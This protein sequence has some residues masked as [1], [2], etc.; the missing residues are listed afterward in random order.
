MG[1]GILEFSIL[2]LLVLVN[3]FFALAEM[4]I[5]SAKDVRLQQMAE[6]G[7]TGAADARRLTKE[8]GSFLS[9]VQIGITLVGVATGAFGGS[10]LAVQIAPL[11]SWIPG[12]GRFAEVISVALMVLL[13]TYLSLVLGELVPKRLAIT[14]PE[15]YA[16]Q[17]A[18]F[19]MRLSRWGRPIVSFLNGS[20]NAVI[21]LL[22]IKSP[23]RPKLTDEDLR[24]LIDQGAETGILNRDEEIM[25]E[26]VLNFD[27]SRIESLITPRS[28]IIWLDIA[29]TQ[30]EIR[31]TLIDHKR[32]KYPVAQGGL[33]RLRGVVYAQELLEQ[34]LEIGHFDLTEILHPPVVVPESLNI[35]TAI[36]RLQKT[37]SG[38]AFV[39]N[40]FG[41][42]D[43]LIADDDLTE[44]LIGFKQASP[45]S[46]DPAIVQRDD[47][48]WLLDGLLPLPT[49]RQLVG[50]K[51]INGD[52]RL[53]QTIGGLM[54]AELGKIP[55]TG[56][57][58]V[59]EGIQLE[60]I[61]MDGNRVD[62]VLATKVQ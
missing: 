51:P 4:A 39:L 35:L 22:R 40:E 42:V 52:E 37:G 26:Q 21:K 10:A 1:I 25:M 29:A 9:T 43:G 27:E 31:E 20:T 49:F 44:A 30:D 17:T 16:S 24:M 28:K 19:M 48:S 55:T 57:C 38:V 32:S 8:S 36:T 50:M 14:N 62:K 12:V 61:D 3:G 2:I 15:K 45:T 41:G 59:W 7:D 56:D 13:I 60:V 5:V 34:H 47:G 23:N 54:M 58:L 53:Y 33:D 6:E 18:T 11:I 46:T